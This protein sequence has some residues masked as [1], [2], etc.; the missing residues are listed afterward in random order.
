MLHPRCIP[1]SPTP[2]PTRLCQDAIKDWLDGLLSGKVRM[3]CRAK[4][5]KEACTLRL[6]RLTDCDWAAPQGAPRDPPRRAPLP[7]VRTAPLQQ[8]PAF[9]AGGEG[10]AEEAGEAAGEVEEEFDLS[11]IMNVSEAWQY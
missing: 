3:G 8:L 6:G 4:K 1:S 5:E 7:Q 11:D 9:P 10:G 2:L